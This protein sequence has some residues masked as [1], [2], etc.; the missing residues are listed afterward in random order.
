MCYMCWLFYGIMSTS[1]ALNRLVYYV[2]SK[3]LFFHSAFVRSCEDEGSAIVIIVCSVDYG[4]SYW[5]SQC[6][7]MTRQ[8]AYI[9]TCLVIFVALFCLLCFTWFGARHRAITSKTTTD[10]NCPWWNLRE[11]SPINSRNFLQNWHW[12]FKGCGWNI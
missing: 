9:A 2:A 7:H 5:R 6:P 4:N 3:Q 12:V 11:K 10:E 8:F 1:V